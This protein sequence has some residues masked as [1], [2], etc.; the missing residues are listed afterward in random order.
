MLALWHNVA[1]VNVKLQRELP[2]TQVLYLHV[3]ELLQTRSTHWANRHAVGTSRK[4]GL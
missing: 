2:E 3:Q 4:L 1:D